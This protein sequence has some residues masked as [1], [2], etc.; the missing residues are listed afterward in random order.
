MNAGVSLRCCGYAYRNTMQTQKNN[1]AFSLTLPERLG[2]CVD[3]VGGKRA[4]AGLIGVSESQIFRYL[5]GL[6]EMTS[7][8]LLAV[9]RVA[10]VDPGWLLSGDGEMQGGIHSSD[11]RPAF[12]GE[13]LVQITQLFEELLVEFEKPFNPRQ[14]A[15]AITFLYNALRHEETMRGIEFVPNKFD[16]LQS[17]NY[18]AQLRSEEEL[19]I[20][21]NALELL[22]Y[23]DHSYLSEDNLE[24]LRT[25]V[26]LVVRGTKGYYSSYPGQVYF[27]RKSGGQLD[28]DAV[29]ELQN[30]VVNTCR[31]VGKTEIDW[32]DLGCGSGRHLIHLYKHFPNV[33]I[34]GVELSQ[35]GYNMCKS[36]ME[37]EKLP[38]DC[39]QMSDARELPFG[40]ESFDAVFA[41]LSLYCLPYIPNTGL[42]LEAAISEVHRILRP[43]GFAHMVFPMGAWRDHSL[44]LQFVDEPMMTELARAFSFDVVKFELEVDPSIAETPTSHTLTNCTNKLKFNHGKFLHITF[45]K[46]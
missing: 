12:R 15:R 25:W 35:L 30:V 16:M 8:K 7:D 46:K 24:L 19:I 37:A 38:K 14:R 2:V 4:L 6:N 21:N 43:N 42:G 26:N 11:S 44:S 22:E 39:V 13:L 31:S 40:S 10:K 29:L 28:P 32:L 3:R 33:K 9:A 41:N 1:I 45:K 36:L 20:L 34:K 17:L 23:S 5:N 18:V 27:E